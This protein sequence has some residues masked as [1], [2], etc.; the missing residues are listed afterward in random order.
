[1]GKVLVL[2]GLWKVEGNLGRN[3]ATIKRTAVKF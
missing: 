2:Y 1:M 3:L